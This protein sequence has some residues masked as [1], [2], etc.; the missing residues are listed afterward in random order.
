MAV[1]V[2]LNVE[3]EVPAAWN[4]ERRRTFWVALK[5]SSCNELVND[6]QYRHGE[7]ED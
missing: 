6:V 2:G 1:M 3:S 5:I 7:N 4:D